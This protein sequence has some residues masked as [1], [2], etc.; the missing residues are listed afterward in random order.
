MNNVSTSDWRGS[1][2]YQEAMDAL[3][4]GKWNEA[5][6]ALHSLEE[7][8]PQDQSLKSLITETELRAE[9]TLHPVRARR[10]TFLNKRVMFVGL[11]MITLAGI[12]WS[13]QAVYATLIAPSMSTTQAAKEQE[14]LAGAAKQAYTKGD[15][16][17]AIELYGQLGQLNPE[18]AALAEGLGKAQ[19]A[20]TLDATYTLA[21]RQITQG[22]AEEA[23]KTLINI[24]QQAPSYRDVASLIGKLERQQRLTELVRQ[25]NVNRA[26]SNWDVVVARLEEALPLTTGAEQDQLKNDLYQARMAFAGEL[27]EASGGQVEVMNRAIDLYGSALTLKPQ[28]P[29]A[30]KQ[31]ND[32]RRF[33]AGYEAFAAG[34]WDDAIAQLELLYRDTPDYLVGKA[35]ELLYNAYMRSAELLTQNNNLMRAWERYTRASRARWGKRGDRQGAGAGSDHAAHAYSHRCPY[36]GAGAGG[37]SRL[38]RSGC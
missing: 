10:F 8:S 4:S 37:R 36:C 29:E 22:A 7:T 33:L 30:I 19:Q 3:Q 31:R 18:H 23:L 27:I 12:G 2:L 28:N 35:V 24:Q 25:V 16:A 32:A 26:Q 5:L 14:Q 21:Q 6:G 34:R 15:N 38:L 20:Q 17:L 1:P 9:S 13:A 11:L